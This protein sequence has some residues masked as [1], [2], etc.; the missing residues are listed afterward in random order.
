HNADADRFAGAILLVEILVWQFADVRAVREPNSLF[1]SNEFG[2]KSKRYKLVMQH[3]Q[4]LPDAIGLDKARLG[5]LF[6]R[7]W[8]ARWADRPNKVEH[9]TVRDV[10]QACPM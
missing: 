3:L 2:H 8:F 9:A 1:A 7:V 6:E 4:E 10:L 5:E